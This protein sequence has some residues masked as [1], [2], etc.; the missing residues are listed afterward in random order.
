M[1]ESDT[2]EY[3]HERSSSAEGQ[4]VSHETFDG[5]QQRQMDENLN[6]DACSSLRSQLMMPRTSDNP[7]AADNGEK[8]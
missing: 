1:F 5:I 3:Q 2:R 8:K 6:T 4:F 7:E